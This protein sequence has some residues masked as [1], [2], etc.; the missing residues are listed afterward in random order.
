MVTK[1]RLRFGTKKWRNDITYILNS[2]ICAS[3]IPT[4]FGTK[5]T[6]QN[7]NTNPKNLNTRDQKMSESPTRFTRP[8]DQKMSES[9][10]PFGHQ[11]RA[12]KLERCSPNLD[13]P[14][15]QH[16]VAK[17]LPKAGAQIFFGVQTRHRKTLALSS[18]YGSN[19]TP[20]SGDETKPPNRER[21]PKSK[22]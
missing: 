20:T 9:P 8:R 6:P 5:T 13:R 1:T 22:T 11:N 3:R 17:T 21:L 10:T 14:H 4:F 15:H 12:A 18:N 2:Q 19:V 7:W 16:V